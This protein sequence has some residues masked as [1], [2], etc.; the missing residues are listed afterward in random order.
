MSK[1]KNDRN[2][3]TKLTDVDVPCVL[4]HPDIELIATSSVHGPGQP[5]A[6][7]AG[8]TGKQENF[9]REQLNKHLYR[10]TVHRNP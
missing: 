1:R 7:K 2:I 9:Y 8:V 10:A 6:A 4:C 3:K 5:P